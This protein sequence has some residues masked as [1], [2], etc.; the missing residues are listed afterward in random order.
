MTP[1]EYLKANP[2]ISLNSFKNAFEK[3]D[4]AKLE[5]IY[6]GFQ[7][8][9][10]TTTNDTDPKTKKNILEKGLTTLEEGL[11]TQESGKSFSDIKQEMIGV[12]DFFDLFMDKTTR[13]FKSFSEVGS[14]FVEMIGKS[15]GEYFDQQTALLEKVNTEAGLTGQ[16]S[17]DFREEI[18]NANPRLLQMGISFGELAESATQL[19]SQTGR[20]SL[21]NQQVFERAGEVA[22]AYVGT[23]QDLVRMYPE[24]EK[25]GIG[26]ANAQEMIG[27]AGKK[28]LE[29]GLRSQTVTA[30]LSKNIGKLN[31]YGF[32]NGVKG[33]EE[34]TRKSIEF[35]S[36]MEDVT[37]IADK[38]FSPE[39]AID[40]A[41]NL[42]V[43]GGVVGDFNDPLKLMYM[44]TN[45]VEGLQDALFGAA[46]SLATYNS[47]Q[48]RFEI[49]GVNLRRAR[50][51]ATELGMSL[52]DLSKTAI[53]AAERTSASADLIAQGL[54]L[55]DD[56][57]RFITN[58][59]QM[60]DGK[61]TIQ[62]QSDFLK[63]QFKANEVALE[64]LDQNQANLLLKY[65]DEF[66]KLSDNDVVRN[67]ATS[68]ENI[69]R[70]VN[71]V[72]AYLRIQGGRA[73]EAAAELAGLDLKEV[74]K[75]TQ[76]MSRKSTEWLES[77]SKFMKDKMNIDINL[78]SNV[79]FG[80]PSNSMTV[81]KQRQMELEKNQQKNQQQTPQNQTNSLPLDDVE[82]L[83]LKLQNA[84]RGQTVI[85]TSID[86][87]N[88]NNYLY[89]K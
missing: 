54:T 1:L 41:A 77:M 25:I 59:A 2:N 81:E 35:R 28:S 4:A 39:G 22:K 79:R 83:Y 63:E 74:A 17:K 57:Q 5:D 9:K 60:K 62:L 37:R 23:L 55:D 42:Q 24:F 84:S 72:A 46:E 30:E 86:Q 51:M 34:M 31:E 65:Q 70:D 50:A 49:S 78:K 3:D 48:G 71:F 69:K 15:A 66:K 53:A 73:G 18:T 43:L 82:R 47:E 36:N 8:T 80:E 12:S 7:N 20:F 89:I 11:K 32:R 56:Q 67:Q 45:N 85:S 75:E 64:D 14:G 40:L 19:V 29:L 58:L 27:E 16:L 38:V 61:M 13:K 88:P 76:Q 68:I 26:A 6:K 33:L 52:S 21:I 44:A 10:K 87:T